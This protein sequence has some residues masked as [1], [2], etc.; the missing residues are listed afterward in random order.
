M[1]LVCVL[2]IVGGLAI[3][4]ACCYIFFRR[5]SSQNSSAQS[6]S[7]T[8]HQGQPSSIVTTKR[9][10]PSNNTHNSSDAKDRNVTQGPLSVDPQNVLFDSRKDCSGARAV[11][12]AKKNKKGTSDGEFSEKE[13]SQMIFRGRLR[14]FFM[15][16]DRARV[17]EVDELT[18]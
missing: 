1:I 10:A 17:S 7:K 11:F 13:T 14:H 16:H 4:G 18:V 8:K 12:L 9:P 3:I 15:L 6:D 2:P 5:Q